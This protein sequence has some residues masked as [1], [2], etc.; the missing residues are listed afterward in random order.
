MIYDDA[1]IERV[2]SLFQTTKESVVIVS[3]FIGAEILERLLESV[4]KRVGEITLYARWR[5]D[6][7]ASGASDWDAWNVAR[8]Y[9]AAM[10]ACD[11][12]HAKIYVSD[13]D[14]L[15]GSAN[16]TISGLG[17]DGNLELLIPA[18]ASHP[19]VAQVLQAVKGNSRLAVPMGVDIRR[20]VQTY[21]Q[22][23]P[24]RVPIWMPAVPPDTFLNAFAGG[25]PH[26][27]AT[28]AICE[29][30]SIPQIEGSINELIDALHAT[31]AF[32]LVREAFRER[33]KPMD[34]GQLRI[35]LSDKIDPII[36]GLPDDQMNVLA[37]WLG[38]F[39]ENTHAT[40]HLQSTSLALSPGRLLETFDVRHKA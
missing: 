40:P 14:A 11:K 4:P 16:A 7:I 19:D 38:R 8:R 37:Q 1:L 6:D 9:G 18:K 39:G 27:E 23:E 32:R 36:K 30:L 29:A 24:L 31:T 5:I 21:S 26:T 3:A 13:D 33:I 10:Y 22:D 12:L 34:V 15:V 28:L 2:C 20:V 17:H 25:S 35:L